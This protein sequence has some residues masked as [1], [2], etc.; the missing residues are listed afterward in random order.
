ME[1][2]VRH[3]RNR[4]ACGKR[5]RGRRKNDASVAQ[6]RIQQNRKSSRRTRRNAA[7]NANEACSGRRRKLRLNQNERGALV[8]ERHVKPS[9]NPNAN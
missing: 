6:D 5:E 3:E 1:R 8:Y 7:H 2:N 9:S 4:M